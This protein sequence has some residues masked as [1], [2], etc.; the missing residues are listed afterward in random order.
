MHAFIQSFNISMYV[1]GEPIHV[2]IM[3]IPYCCKMVT[4]RAL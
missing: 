4:F 1:D 2:S 3:H